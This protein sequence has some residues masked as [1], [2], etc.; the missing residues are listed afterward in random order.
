M[1][2]T[3]STSA[4]A[5]SPARPSPVRRA[6]RGG[7]SQRPPRSARRSGATAAAPTRCGHRSARKADT[8]GTGSSWPR[9][10]AGSAIL[11]PRV[12]VCG[13]CRR[14]RCPE[15]QPAGNQH[16]RGLL[17]QYAGRRRGSGTAA[18]AGRADAGPE[19]AFRHGPPW[20]APSP[21]RFRGVSFLARGSE[22]RHTPV[23]L[24]CGEGQLTCPGRSQGSANQIHRSVGVGQNRN[25]WMFAPPW[26]EIRMDSDHHLG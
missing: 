17:G 3:R 1:F 25:L 15:C 4:L 16:L 22:P 20:L 2:F 21:P 19:R 18:R 14:Y 9:T 24:S 23:H 10:D 26:G 8:I 7:S 12:T 11:P 5:C 6:S 13:Q